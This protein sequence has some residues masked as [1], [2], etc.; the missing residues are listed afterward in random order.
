MHLFGDRRVEL[1]G[2]TEVRQFNIALVSNEHV[3]NVFVEDSHPII[4][5]DV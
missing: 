5:E 2:I 3:V 4:Y 1:N